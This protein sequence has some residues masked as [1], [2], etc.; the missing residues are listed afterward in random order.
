MS[1]SRQ[2][3]ASV[4]REAERLRISRYVLLRRLRIAGKVGP[5]TYTRIVADWT[6]AERVQRQPK[7]FQHPVER[8]LRERGPTFVSTVLEANRRNLISLADVTDYL[9]LKVKHIDTLEAALHE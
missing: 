1:K 6:P 5:T 9:G 8:C 3:A 7:G 2:S 4:V